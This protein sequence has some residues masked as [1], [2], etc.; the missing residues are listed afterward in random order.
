MIRP[1][2]TLRLLLAGVALMYLGFAMLPHA[3]H[4]QDATDQGADADT[5]PVMLGALR[6][7]GAFTRATLPN[8][9]SGG[10]YLRVTN[11]GSVP[12]RLVAVKAD[13]AAL[14]QLHQMTVVDG[15]M[16]MGELPDGIE[17]PPG[18]TVSLAPGG[19]HIMFMG[20]K[21][22]FAEGQTVPV[23]LQFEKAGETTVSLH[24]EGVSAQAP[25]H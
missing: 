22:A 25:A 10:G 9:R 14:V 19:M 18:E 11:T 24:V 16:R 8:A 12:D 6:I 13:A 2:R 20:L 17:I 7:D 21:E 1:N 4:A 5:A 15:M 3:A 23:T